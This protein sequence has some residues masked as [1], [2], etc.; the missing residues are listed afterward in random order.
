MRDATFC[1]ADPTTFCRM[2]DLGLEVV[3]QQP[4][5]D[6]A[7]LP[8]RVVD[9]DDWCQDTTAAAASRVKLSTQ[10]VVWAL[11]SVV[12]DRMSIARIT[13]GLGVSWNTVN[14][15][16]LATGHQLLIADPTRFAESTRQNTEPARR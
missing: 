13:A 3:D 14:D 15:A 4:H 2:D 10:A 16:V 9:P 7:M 6:H 11:K 12:I 1:P 5:P 8:C